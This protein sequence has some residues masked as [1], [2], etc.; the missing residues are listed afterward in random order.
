MIEIRPVNQ[1]TPLTEKNR[2][3]RRQFLKTGLSVYSSLSLGSILKLNEKPD[4][5]KRHFII[6]HLVGGN[7]ALNTVVPYSDSDYYRVRRNLSL[8]PA[9]LI[10]IDRDYALHPSLVCLGSLYQSGKLAFLLGIGSPEH[11]LS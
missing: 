3:S 1:V 10:K 9:E 8:K 11:S 6:L 5:S 7:D 2:Y 4:F